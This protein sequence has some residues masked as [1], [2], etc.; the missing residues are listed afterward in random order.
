MSISVDIVVEAGDWA[1]IAHAERTI[2][3]AANAA[4]AHAADTEVAMVLTDDRHMQNLNRTWRGIDEPTNVLSFPA[5]RLD[6]GPRVLGDVVFALETIE[7]EAAAADKPVIDHLAHLTV[8]GALHLL[9]FDHVRETDAESMERR[10]R[11]ILA[12]LGVPDPYAVSE[13]SM[14]DPA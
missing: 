14:T 6:A 7:R 10:E 1:R 5:P 3:R 11:A 2:R 9:G 8:H 13:Q 12:E 4:L